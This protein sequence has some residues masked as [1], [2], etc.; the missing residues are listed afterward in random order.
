MAEEVLLYLVRLLEELEFDAVYAGLNPGQVRSTV[1]W[2]YVSLRQRIAQ[3]QV[4]F[5]RD[6]ETFRHVTSAG[7]HDLCLSFCDFVRG[8]VRERNVQL[9]AVF[10]APKQILPAACVVCYTPTIVAVGR[11]FVQSNARQ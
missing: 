11:C 1:S 5:M 2:C 4:T 3:C 10:G 8:M 7:K 9:N 6:A